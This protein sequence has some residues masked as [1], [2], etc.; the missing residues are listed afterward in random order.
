MAVKLGDL[1]CD[2]P[3]VTEVD[4]NPVLALADGCLV[5]DARILVAQPCLADAR[6]T[7]TEADNS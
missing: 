4:L 2:L 3:E 6:P 7:M 5:L 1:L